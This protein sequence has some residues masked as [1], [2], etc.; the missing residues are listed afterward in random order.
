MVIHRLFNKSVPEYLARH[1]WWAYLW[2]PAVWFFDHQPII[3][4]ILFGQYRALMDRTLALFRKYSRG[5]TLQLSCVYGSLTP[6]ILRDMQPRPLHITDVSRVQLMK[7]NSKITDKNRLLM[8]RMNAE[9]L[10]Y[11][12][13]SFSTVIIFF[14]LHEL[15]TDARRLALAEALRVLTPDGTLLIT[16]YGHQPEQN[17]LTRF[18]PSRFL[19]TH[20]EPFLES[21]W[22]EDIPCLLNQL[23]Q[24]L[25]KGVELL[26][27]ENVYSQ[28][29]QVSAYKIVH[30]G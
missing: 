14:L 10:A 20:F 18:P 28:L 13:N 12:D 24:P 6:S 9:H 2:R 30:S 27:Q 4:L 11:A 1:Y 7:L 23:G 8:T 16:E 19:F 3:N 21:F 17:F 5:E 26:S 22:A 29:Y 15:P 25:D